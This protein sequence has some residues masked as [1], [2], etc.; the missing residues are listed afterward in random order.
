MIQDEEFAMFAVGIFLFTQLHVA[1][2]WFLIL[3][4]L[5]DIR[6]AGYLW[7]KKTGDCHYTESYNRSMSGEGMRLTGIIGF[8]HSSLSGLMHEK[9][10]VGKSIRFT[11]VGIIGKHQ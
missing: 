4:L 3:F 9:L 11:E 5:P 8:R 7:N 1:W 6:N 10:K 2:W